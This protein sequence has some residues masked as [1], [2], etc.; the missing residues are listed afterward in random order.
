MLIKSS[1]RLLSRENER[2]KRRFQR[3][4]LSGGGSDIR[5]VRNI[6]SL[7]KGGANVAKVS[8]GGALLSAS[9]GVGAPVGAALETTAAIGAGISV[10]GD[11]VATGMYNQKSN[12]LREEAIL[13][14]DPMVQDHRTLAS[15]YM[16]VKAGR[17]LKDAGKGLVDLATEGLGD[18]FGAAGEAISA[19]AEDQIDR[20]R[21]DDFSDVLKREL[22]QG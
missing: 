5:R 4:E 20:Y 16:D 18:V 17:R 12:Q 21:A 10:L 19:A 3:E 13:S 7:A 22:S 15:Q 2:L 9:T 8:S 1:V 14:N 6:E 11:T